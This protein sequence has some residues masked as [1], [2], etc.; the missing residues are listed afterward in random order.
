MKKIIK[1]FL[2]IIFIIILLLGSVNFLVFLKSKKF[3]YQDINNIEKKKVALVLGARVYSD[4]R[5]SD[6]LHDRVQSA[7]ELYQNGKVE[8]ILL[9]GDHGR[10]NY[11]EVS[12]MRD[13][14]LE[15]GVPGNDIFLDHA[16]FDTYDSMYRARDVFLVDSMIVVTQEFHL[17]RAVY[18]ARSLDVDAIGFVADKQHYLFMVRNNI[19]ESLARIKAFFNVLLHSN[20]KFLGDKIPVSGNGMITWD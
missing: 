2:V 5:L 7:L 19:R 3:V 18:I 1:I 8:K 17:P 15:N 16:G 9:S 20:P 11:D 6:M 10:E 13:Y 14:L 4:G 12:A